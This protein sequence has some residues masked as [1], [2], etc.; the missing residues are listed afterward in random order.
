VPVFTGR[1][2]AQ[3]TKTIPTGKEE[4]WQRIIAEAAEQSRRGRIPELMPAVTFN[5]AVGGLDSGQLALLPWEKAGDYALRDALSG[6]TPD[7]LSLFIGP[8]GGFSEG[9]V[10]YARE[11]GIIPVSLGPRIL[12]AETAAVVAAAMVLYQLGELT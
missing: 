5:E 3:G 1:S 10:A 12:R 8:E 9:E 6:R 2:I 11:R 7:S 4:R